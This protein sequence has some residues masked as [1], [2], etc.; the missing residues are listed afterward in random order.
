MGKV[1]AYERGTQAKLIT[2]ASATVPQVG[3]AAP[4][5][6]DVIGVVYDKAGRQPHSAAVQIDLTGG[7]LSA[8]V[9][10]VL[11][12][13]D[14]VNFYVIASFNAV[15]GSGNLLGLVAQWRYLS[16]SITTF[17]GSGGSPLV[18]VSIGGL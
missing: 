12:S 13:L 4:V 1:Y 11:G 15:T 6:A 9:V 5:G 17:T 16:V 14:G 10:N 18:D 2:G 3:T 8:L 7:T